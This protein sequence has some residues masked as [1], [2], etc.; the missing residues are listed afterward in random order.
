MAANPDPDRT[1]PSPPAI[2]GYKLFVAWRYLLVTPRKIR[3]LT[4]RLLFAGLATLGLIALLRALHLEPDTTML[5]NPMWVA[6]VV[7]G[8]FLTMVVFSGVLPHSKPALI[9]SLIGVAA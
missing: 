6:E 2:G 1:I 3:P 4:H 5:R 7:V 8:L 9:I